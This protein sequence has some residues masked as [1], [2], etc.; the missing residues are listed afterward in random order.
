MQ[1]GRGGLRTDLRVERE[2]H[3]LAP[4]TQDEAGAPFAM[5]AVE[6][7]HGFA[8]FQPEYVAKV[9]LLGLVQRQA[10]AAAE[11]GLDV[12]AGSGE[13]VGRHGARLARARRPGERTAIDE[14][15]TMVGCVSRAAMIAA[16]VLT[17]AGAAQAGDCNADIGGLSAKR[18]SFIEKLNVLA[19]SAK[20]KLDP[21][22]SC[23]TLRGLVGAEGALLKYLEANKAWCNV[24]DEAVGN[25]KQAAGKSQQFAT[26]ACNLATQVKQQQKQ[27]ATA[28]AL[29]VEAQKLPTGPL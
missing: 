24:P 6:D 15:Q 26:Q 18:Q 12:E 5:A 29:G 17:G 4:G 11:V 8:L 19:K 3:R 25:L 1:G 23:P 21:V 10:R 27:A 9:V 16:V 13:V 2:R 7:Q 28:P 22:A 14:G 20:G